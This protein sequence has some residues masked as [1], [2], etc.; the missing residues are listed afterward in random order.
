MNGDL[1]KIYMGPDILSNREEALQL[2]WIVTN[3]QGGYASSTVLGTNTRKYHGLLIASMNPP[4]D[5]RVVLTKLDETAQIGNEKH[6]L[7]T[8]EFKSGLQPDDCQLP[9]DFWLQPFPTFRYSSDRFKLLKTIFMPQGFNA[10]IVQYEASNISEDTMLLSIS[11]LV[12]SRH[13]HSVMTK[14]GLEG[15]FT[16]THLKNNIVIE[17]SD[18]STSLV[19]SSN[20]GRYSVGAKWIRAVK[21]RTDSSRGNSCFDDG[22]QP[23]SF[24]VEVAPKEKT[25]FCITAAA[26]ENREEAERILTA[27]DSCSHHA[28]VQLNQELQRQKNLLNALH[29]QYS[30]I[31]MVS[32]LKWLVHAADSFIVNRRST[33][34]KSM[35]AGY[36]WFEDW[37]RDSMI[38]LS[39]LT[40]I[41]GQARVAEDILLTFQQYC[42]KG[43]VPNRF[44]DEA[45]ESPSYNTVD[46]SLWYF[47]AV[48]QYLK[49]TDDFSFVRRHLWDTLQSIIEHHLQGTTN[50]IHMDEDGLLAHGPQLTWMDATIDNKAVTPRSGKAVEIQALWYNA[51]KISELL[52]TRF[53]QT[54]LAARYTEIAARTKESFTEKFWNPQGH[55]LFDAVSKNHPD[56]SVRPNQII[57]VALDFSL[58]TDARARATVEKVW[59]TLWGM[60][61]LKTLDEGDPRYCGTY[62]GNLT[63]RNRAYHN[64]TVWAWLLGPFIT[65]FLKINAFEERWRDFAYQNFLKPL[66]ETQMS[67]AGLGTISEI[68]DGDSPHTPRGCISQ[69]WSVAEPLRAFVEDVKLKRPPYEREVLSRIPH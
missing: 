21:F 65:S 36:H 18:R 30:D 50:N 67:K 12:S 7:S 64:G 52:A 56:A 29:D 63:C 48:F 58:L 34:R 17:P 61:G 32:W 59:R 69:A 33:Q 60:Y 14:D 42:H 25:R 3:G 2:E 9:S 44:P 39:G 1:P 16:Q 6:I 47:H 40:L 15:G 20:E 24:I 28:T 51:L 5:R 68:F 37:G 41:T 45:G 62:H 13:F 27:V 46:A 57:A 8:N 22:F 31:Q 26:G 54:K 4:V 53:Q 35:I 10:S 49:Y 66:F 38:S 11:P 43:L 19:L 23:G 55:Y